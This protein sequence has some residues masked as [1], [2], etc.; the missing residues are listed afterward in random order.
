M[1]TRVWNTNFS[2]SSKIQCSEKKFPDTYR[3]RKP[4]KTSSAKQNS[5][6]IN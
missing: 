6:K 3:K 1:A 4:F 5:W 2:F